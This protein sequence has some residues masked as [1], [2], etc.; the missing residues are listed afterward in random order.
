[1]KSARKH[2]LF[3][4]AIAACSMGCFV[5]QPNAM[6]VA[7]IAGQAARQL[8]GGAAG[9][10]AR[11]NVS[12]RVVVSDSIPDVELVRAELS[13]IL[14]ARP[15]TATDSSRLSLLVHSAQ[16][17]G[18]VL[19]LGLE[20]VV[21]QRCGASWASSMSYSTAYDIRAH[22]ERRAW[23]VDSLRPTSYGD[24]GRCVT[25]PVEILPPA[26]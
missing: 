21:I 8:T 26:T 14:A 23:I 4:G 15:S 22:E 19:E 11:P 7:D 6:A 9:S 2:G 10:T 18:P 3:I 25:G 20:L 17:R 13:R 12:W 16:R 5:R 24:L 1:M